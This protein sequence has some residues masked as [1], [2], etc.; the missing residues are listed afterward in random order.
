MTTIRPPTKK[1]Q[2]VDVL[3]K[4]V[5]VALLIKFDKIADRAHRDR[6]HQILALMEEAVKH[7]R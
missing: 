5:P 4:N 2:H 6:Y 7:G 3:V 1:K